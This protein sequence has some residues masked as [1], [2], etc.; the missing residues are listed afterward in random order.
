MN[1]LEELDYTE[2]ERNSD[3]Y[4]IQTIDKCIGA[5]VRD[6]DYLVKAY[7]YYHGVRDKE[8]YSYLEDTFGIDAATSI[9]MVPLIRRHINFL[10]GKLLGSKINTIISCT[11]KGTIEEMQKEKA[12]GVKQYDRE[13]LKGALFNNIKISQ[14]EKPEQ[15]IQDDIELLRS[16]F[17]K[18]FR[19][20]YEQ[21]AQHILKIIKESPEIDLTEKRERL[22]TDLLITGTCYY[23][24]KSYHDNAMPE[25]E[26][27]NPLEVFVEKNRNSRSI[28]YSNRAVIRRRMPLHEVLN[29]YGHHLT[30]SQRASLGEVRDHGMPE[31][32]YWNPGEG[33]GLISNYIESI[34]PYTDGNYLEGFTSQNLLTVYEVEWLV[35]NPVKEGRKI[36]SYRVDRYRGVKIGSDIYIDMG[37]D[38][39][40]VR[41][42]SDPGKCG[43]SINGLS[44]A[45]RNGRPYSLVLACANLQDRYD[46]L[47]FMQE[48]LISTS[49]VKGQIV[50]VST[51]PLHLGDTPEERIVASMVMRKQ[52]TYLIDTAAEGDMSGLNTTFNGYDDTV[53]PNSINAIAIAMQHI[54]KTCSSI[55]G[56]YE[57][58]LQGI[59]QRD[60]VANVRVGIENS[61]VITKPLYQTINTVTRDLIL[62][63]MNVFKQSFSKGYVGTML[64]NQETVETINLDPKYYTLTDY[65]V[66]VVDSDEANTKLDNMKKLA[67][68]FI[69][70]GSVGIDIITKIINSDSIEEINSIVDEATSIKQQ[71]SQQLQQAQ[72]Q[73][74]QGQNTISQLERELQQLRSQL[75]AKEKKDSELKKYEVTEKFKIERDKLDLQREVMIKDIEVKKSRTELEK[76]QIFDN[77]PYNDKI[78]NI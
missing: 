16:N 59:E 77:N 70:T 52:G 51:I 25:I 54:E 17:S 1:N 10:V 36:V 22:F 23:R 9:T 65:G 31:Q 55:T 18:K 60:A 38:E 39:T 19:T 66:F 11:D 58:N 63:A 49:G 71:A 35:S 34:A 29:K 21:A 2:K 76:L 50:N 12:D 67:P 27:L 42:V 15:Q 72:Q 6:K 13:L 56:V 5:L 64:L 24:V 14:G 40:A 7:N 30:P 20:N 62:D 37:I 68:E 47:N 8:Q 3:D 43:L 46:L 48:Y 44:Y 53:D 75:E 33:S 57:E 32:V 78:K 4:L 28:K 26:V 69:K 74:E 45:D 61:N 73:M 41:T